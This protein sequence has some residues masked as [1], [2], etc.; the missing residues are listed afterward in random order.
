M[1]EPDMREYVRKPK[2]AKAVQWH[3]IGDHPSVVEFPGSI[4]PQYVLVDETG[5]YIDDVEPTDWIAESVFGGLRAVADDLFRARYALAAAERP[6]APPAVSLPPNF[7]L[8]TPDDLG[9]I[10]R[11]A[12]VRWAKTQPAPK[13]HWLVPYDELGEPDKEAD[14]QIGMA[15]VAAIVNE[16]LQAAAVIIQEAHRG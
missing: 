9:R 11:E 13:P 6:A 15:V 8:P 1:S 16:A 5:E 2:T 7:S 3:K 10:V 14:R 12:W 4:P